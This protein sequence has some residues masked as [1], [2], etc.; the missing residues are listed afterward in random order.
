MLPG[1]AGA[2]ITWNHSRNY[3]QQLGLESS[4]GLTGLDIHD[5]HS[6]AWQLLLAIGLELRWSCHS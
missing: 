2:V 5:A 3:S 4:E 1:L 6:H